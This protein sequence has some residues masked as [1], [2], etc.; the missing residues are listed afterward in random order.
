MYFLYN[1]IHHAN[2]LIHIYIILELIIDF[3]NPYK[4]ILYDVQG[5]KICDLFWVNSP[6]T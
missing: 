6:S 3:C 1:G 2:L 4:T 5:N